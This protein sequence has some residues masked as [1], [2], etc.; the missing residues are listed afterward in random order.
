MG[1]KLKSILIVLLGLIM[2]S[3]SVSCNGGFSDGGT[4]ASS[5]APAQSTVYAS[6]TASGL[7]N[8]PYRIDV[9]TLVGN[10]SGDQRGW[11]A[12]I[13]KDKFN[14]EM[15]IISSNIEGG[16]DAKFATMMASGDLGD[17]VVFGSDADNKWLDAISGGY[18][19]DMAGS[20]ILDKYGK[21]IVANYP[22][23]I[24]KN[25]TMFG[26]GIGVY[27]LGYLAA[28]MPPGPSEGRDMTEHTDMRW[29]LY[30]KLEKPVINS[31]EEMLGVLKDMQKLEPRSETGKP[32]YAFSIWSDWDGNMMMYV[33]AF[34]AL[35]GYDEGDGFNNVG[36][37]L[38]NPEG[39]MQGCL[40]D[41][42]WYIRILRLLYNANRIGLV[43][44][45]SISQKFN[46]V[47]NKY[48]DG[49]L[50]FSLFPF[51]DNV[52]NTPDRLAQG[53]AM[54][55]VPVGGEKI[56]SYGFNQYGKDR[57]IS[58]GSKAEK[59][60]RIMELI[61][62][63]YTPEGFSTVKNGPRG[64]TWNL[65][66]EGKP[67][68]TDFGRRALPN[69]EVPVPEEWGGGNFK[70]GNNQWNIDPID[71]FSI[72]PQFNEPYDY[73][74]W[75]SVLKAEV[76]KALQ[77]W[78]AAMGGFMSA[79]DYLIAKN[80]IVVKQP[81]YTGKAPEAMPETLTRKQ[82]QCATVI[83][84]YSWKCIFARDDAEFNSLLNGMVSKSKNLGYEEVLKWNKAHGQQVL[85]F[86]KTH[87]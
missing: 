30:E 46:D 72:N 22:K 42:G 7:E 86:L 20:G 27:G 16:S 73:R 18:L 52:Y 77:N 4:E 55:L 25:R 17:V 85:D 36:F 70:D 28:N 39:D 58:I 61:N 63:M 60:E 69:N 71:A 68:L 15:N 11:F 62:W 41:S 79:K 21:D 32:T 54:Y 38:F 80:M 34:A 13:I 40:D 6:A 29:D 5:T 12:K 84:E 10:Y 47:V 14:I 1:G 24:E 33:K 59:P 19:L 48:K 2:S 67:V 31:P 3:V 8:A 26:K 81:V 35:F 57:L 75:S 64:L 53:K 37:L 51:V 23:V 43:D 56:I 82:V 78:R 50:L 83:K 45:D 66:A 44:P 87:P 65:D 49:Q 9:F 76:P 74:M